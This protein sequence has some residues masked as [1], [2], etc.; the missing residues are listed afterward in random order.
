[1]SLDE[2]F[3]LEKHARAAGAGSLGE[4]ALVEEVRRRYRER[5]GGSLVDLLLD[6][7]LVEARHRTTEYERLLAWLE[8]PNE[9]ERELER[10][11]RPH[12]AF[13]NLLRQIDEANEAE[14]IRLAK[15]QGGQVR[16]ARRNALVAFIAASISSSDELD[17]CDRIWEWLRLLPRKLS[18]GTTVDAVD[19]ERL[20]IGGRRGESEKVITRN[21]VR[22]Y[23]TDARKLL[24]EAA[25]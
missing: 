19:G 21:T 14:R 16:D 8:A 24:K 18:D 11:R 20:R 7:E 13:E 4:D 3:A 1:M 23:V 2:L 17:T 22:R 10:L 5:G 6:E 12:E 9:L 25:Q 15:S